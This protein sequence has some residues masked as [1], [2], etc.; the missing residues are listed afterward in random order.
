[1]NIN[2]ERLS[3]KAGEAAD[4]LRSLSNPHRLMILCRLALGESPVGEIALALGLRDAAVSRHLAR[5]RH[6]G[7]VAGRRDGQTIRYRLASPAAAAVLLA[8]QNGARPLC[9]PALSRHSAKGLHDDN[10][11]S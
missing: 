5:L 1:M 2:S 11:G 6:D 4:L 10:P 8:L 9:V 7:L 3:G